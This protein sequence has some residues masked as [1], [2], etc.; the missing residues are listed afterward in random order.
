M[1]ISRT[2]KMLAGLAMAGT[3]GVGGL[4]VAA[5]NPLGQVG[6]AAGPSTTV[7]AR[8]APRPGMPMGARQGDHRPEQLLKSVLDSLV[9]DGT[10]NQTQADK[11]LAAVKAKAQT[12]MARHRADHQARHTAM[13]ETAA[14]AI[15]ISTTDLD[16]ALRSGKTLADVAKSK[17]VDPQKVVD[18]L[19]TEANTRI[20]KA[21]TDG[22]LTAEQA[23]TEKAEAATRIPDMVN[24]G[25]PGRGGPD[26]RGHG[27]PRGMGGPGHGGPGDMGGPD[28]IGGPGGN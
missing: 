15:G 20:D 11:I 25:R 7:A 8:S 10:I 12:E 17:G 22:K 13:L 18:A 14:K 2:K 27:G 1:G 4:A 16:T 6:A 19:I 9:K 21:V 26:G 3:V 24:N 23:A 28:G 5:V